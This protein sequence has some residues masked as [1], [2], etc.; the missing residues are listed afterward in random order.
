MPAQGRYP[1]IANHSSYGGEKF[2]RGQSIAMERA[3]RNQGPDEGPVILRLR[4][5]FR[6]SWQRI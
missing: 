1:S 5:L 6:L 4:L 2:R 3:G